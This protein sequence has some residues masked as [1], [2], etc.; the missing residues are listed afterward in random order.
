MIERGMDKQTILDYFSFEGTYTGTT[1]EA[2]YVDGGG[3]G[4]SFW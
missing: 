1:K 4:A 3:E 2:A